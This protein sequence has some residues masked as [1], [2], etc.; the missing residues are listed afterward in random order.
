MSSVAKNK[1]VD[2]QIFL[3]RRFGVDFIEEKIVTKVR[4]STGGRQMVRTVRR[5]DLDNRK[6]ERREEKKKK[7]QKLQIVFSSLIVYNIL[8]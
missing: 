3:F 4:C 1:K 7:L 5:S 6:R 8:L 2:R